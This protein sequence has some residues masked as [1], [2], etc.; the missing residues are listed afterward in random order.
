MQGNS[1]LTATQPE[2]AG[3]L[4]ANL[5]SRL[6]AVMPRFRELL[7]T[8]GAAE[9]RAE[10]TQGLVERSIARAI[11]LVFNQDQ[12][13]AQSKQIGGRQQGGLTADVGRRPQGGLT[14]D[15]GRRPQGG[16]PT[17]VGRR[18]QGGLAVDVGRR[19]QGGLTTDVGRRPQ[20]GLTAG[21]ERRQQGGL[22]AGAVSTVQR[23]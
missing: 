19:P 21:V 20:A 4:V 8:P 9:I 6:Q 13:S 22:T 18:P 16:L 11:R 15:V 17:D 23:L 3:Q 5:Q 2:G 10:L 12:S 1:N 14:A 7:N